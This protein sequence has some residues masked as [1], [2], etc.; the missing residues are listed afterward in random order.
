M[1]SFLHK[2]NESHSGY[3]LQGREQ[4]SKKILLHW[5]SHDIPRSKGAS[6]SEYLAKGHHIWLPQIM[7][8]P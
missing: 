6:D 3:S 8:I 4:S 5:P 2:I 1:V 7:I